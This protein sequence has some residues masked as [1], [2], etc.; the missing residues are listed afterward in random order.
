[1]SAALDR[2]ALL[3]A[4]DSIG[5]AAANAGTKLQIAV[6]GGSALMLASNFRFATEDVDVS[7]LE[8]PLPDWLKRITAEIAARNGWDADWFNDHVVFHLSPLADRAADHLEFGTFPR[9][10]TSPGLEVS[11]P[12]AAYLLALKLKAFR[13]TDPIRGEME[14]LDMNLMK[15]VGIST[16]DEAIALLGRYFPVSAASSEKQRFLLKNMDLEGGA[17]APKYP[18]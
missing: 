14:R 10:G 13:I 4:F 2:E 11:V 6:Y 9:D 18:R 5:R 16:V 7:K 1:M 8:H 17:D 15:V 3:D 12:T